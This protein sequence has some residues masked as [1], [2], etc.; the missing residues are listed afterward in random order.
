MDGTGW[1]PFGADDQ[2]V[3]VEGAVLALLAVVATVAVVRARRGRISAAGLWESVGATQSVAT[4]VCVAAGAPRILLPLAVGAG[5]CAW[6]Y[7]RVSAEVDCPLCALTGER[8]HA[9]G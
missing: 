9:G 7:D 4:A 5:Y 8:G 2:A 1:L 3:L 6:R